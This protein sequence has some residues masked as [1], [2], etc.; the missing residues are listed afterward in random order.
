MPLLYKEKREYGNGLEK[1]EPND[2]NKTLILDFEIIKK[3]DLD[4]LRR[5][6]IE[7]FK[8]NKKNRLEIFNKADLILK[9]YL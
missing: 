5:L 7:I 4:E 2:L 3:E 1:F 9:N 6:Q 8:N